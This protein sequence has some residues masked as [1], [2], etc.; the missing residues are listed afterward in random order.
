M[1]DI[2]STDRRLSEST[3]KKE[4]QP[5]VANIR[6]KEKEELNHGFKLSVVQKSAVNFYTKWKLVET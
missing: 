6:V 1:I 3:S 2:L 4:N 5:K